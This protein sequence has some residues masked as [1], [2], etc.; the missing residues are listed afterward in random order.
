MKKVGIQIKSKSS[1]IPNALTVK[2]I[3]NAHKGIGICK[4][5]KDIEKFV[6]SIK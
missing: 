6:K 5:I 4:P 1:N 3:E 2:I